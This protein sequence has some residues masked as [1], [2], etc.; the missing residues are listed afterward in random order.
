[1][2]TLRAS[3]RLVVVLL[4]CLW[5][6]PALA[7]SGVSLL[8]Y[9]PD[10]AEALGAV[11]LAKS[12]GTALFKK[13][14]ESFAGEMGESW[15]KLKDAKLDL[16]K[17][18]DTMLVAVK[19]VADKQVFAVVMEGRLTAFEAE[20]RKGASELKQGIAV[21]AYND[22]SMLFFDKKFIVC[23]TALTDQMLDTL[24]VKRPSLKTSRKGKTLRAAV[25]GTELRGDAW[26]V[27][28]GK[29]LKDLLP[30]SGSVLWLSA[31]MS[32]SKGL[33]TEIKLA[34]D[35]EE[36]ATELA[37]WMTGQLPMAKSLLGSQGFGTMADSI[38]VK[39]TGA[40]LVVGA[41]MSD[42]E[43]TKVLSYLSRQAGSAGDVKSP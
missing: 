38:E 31:S 18:V 33:A 23:S 42:G 27:G 4:A 22:L 20:M 10:D 21:W 14:L 12:R 30:V 24:K 8:R 43:L 26:M 29:P 11:N 40:L 16:G 34:A 32:S 28:V 2:P 39:N 41:V 5:A 25:A 35:T 19:T 15:K 37:T 6:A 9:A 36:T 7:G 17:D 13:G 3:L 1:M